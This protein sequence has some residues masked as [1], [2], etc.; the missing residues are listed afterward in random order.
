MPGWVQRIQT[1]IDKCTDKWTND[2]IKLILTGAL[3]TQRN[4]CFSRDTRKRYQTSA[5]CANARKHM[6]QEV[7]DIYLKYNLLLNEIDDDNDKLHLICW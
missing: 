4:F 5:T 2:I 1:Y 6:Y 3:E 7:H